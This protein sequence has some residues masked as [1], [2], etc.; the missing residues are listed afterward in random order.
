MRWYL[1][2]YLGVMCVLLLIGWRITLSENEKLQHQ[3]IE[4]CV[5]LDFTGITPDY[6]QEYINKGYS[7]YGE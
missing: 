1:V 3:I 6:C 7:I 2:L 4:N 5:W